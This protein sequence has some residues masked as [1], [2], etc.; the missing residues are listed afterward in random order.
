MNITINITG[1]RADFDTYN[2]QGCYWVTVASEEFGNEEV[3][4]KLSSDPTDTETR[5]VKHLS[6]EHMREEVDAIARDYAERMGWDI[7][8]VSHD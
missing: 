7:D 6:T 2:E 4:V 8:H 1:T 5:K 3:E